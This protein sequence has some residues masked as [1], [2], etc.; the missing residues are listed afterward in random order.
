MTYTELEQR[1]KDG[2]ET[3]LERVARAMAI[4]DGKNPDDPRWVRYPGPET[5]GLCWHGYKSK[6]IAAVRALREPNDV[7]CGVGQELYMDGVN[8]HQGHPY[9]SDEAAFQ[10]FRAMIDSILADTEERG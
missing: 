4:A 2:G 3:M 7:M 5:Y 1:Q 6:A 10:L 9:A 8:F